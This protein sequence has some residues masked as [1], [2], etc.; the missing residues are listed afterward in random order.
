MPGS[1]VIVA[2]VRRVTAW[3]G[4]GR[5][6][7]SSGGPDGC[8]ARA[9]SSWLA[10]AVVMVPWRPA[11]SARALGQSQPDAS[12]STPWCGRGGVG[13]AVL[14]PGPPAGAPELPGPGGQH[15]GRGGGANGR[16]CCVWSGP[17][18]GVLGATLAFLG[19][20]VLTAVHARVLADRV[21]AEEAQGPRRWPPG[22]GATLRQV[23]DGDRRLG[24]LPSLARRPRRRPTTPGGGARPVVLDSAALAMTGRPPEHRRHRLRPRDRPRL[25]GSYAAVSVASKAV[26]FG[27]VALGGYLLPE[28]AI[29]WRRA[30]MPSGS[31]R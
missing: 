21:W 15:R 6:T 27:A 9:P 20:E 29:R 13:P 7:W 19:A 18:S 30:A 8:T 22:P 2:V 23:G 26:V 11:R 17:A 25:S 14:G 3:R 12:G 16:P 28:A 10:F 4:V 1:A 31:W 5:R 24:C